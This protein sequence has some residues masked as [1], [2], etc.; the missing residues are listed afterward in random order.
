MATK[1]LGLIAMTLAPAGPSASP[2]LVGTC[3]HPG[4]RAVYY[5]TFPLLEVQHSFYQL[6]SMRVA[7]KWRAEA[8]DGFVFVIKAW[9]LIT[10]S[11][12]SPTYRRLTEP[13]WGDPAGFGGFRP[14]PEVS[15]ARRRTRAWALALGAKMVLFQCPRSLGPSERS[16]AHLRTFFGAA[17]RGGMTFLWEPRGWP[18][19]LVAELCAELD[20]QHCVDPFLDRQAFGRLAYWRLHGQ[21]AY[22]YDYRYTD[23]ELDQIRAWALAEAAAERPVYV[24]FN[25]EV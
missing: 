14:T 3:G 15:E 24:M 1:G 18:T 23:G 4:K 17:D 12:H 13:L 22:H 9:Q 5:Q 11:R 8:P 19:P 10:H 7:E 16:V 6:P 20:L 25:N 2:I 21:P